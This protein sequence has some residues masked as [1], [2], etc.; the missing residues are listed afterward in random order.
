VD[1]KVTNKAG[2][3]MDVKADIFFVNESGLNEQLELEKD[4]E[5]RVPSAVK[6]GNNITPGV[7][8]F[9]TKIPEIEF[10]NGKYPTKLKFDFN[11]ITN[12]DG[13]PDTDI[14]FIVK[15]NNDTLA[16]VD[17]TFT[18]PLYIK[19]EEY[20][21]TDTASFDYNDIINDDEEFSK[22]I[23]SMTINLAIANNLP[24]EITLAA[25]AVDEAGNHVE[26]ILHPT[27]VTKGIQNIP[28]SL[29]QY[30]LERF[31][32]ENVKDIVLYT[33]AKTTSGGYVEVKDDSFL[34]IAIS[35]NIK[36]D[37]PNIFE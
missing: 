36:A 9:S 22:S 37:I 31:K 4:F 25:I 15:N 5:I 14:N 13:D 33:T 8:S 1:A 29:I 7:K 18:V 3:P 24:F 12:P 20:S 26:P 35:I 32:S 2:L 19:V 27:L 28:I 30:Q 6:S 11:G 34:N 23:E 16:K 10:E 17:F 21:R